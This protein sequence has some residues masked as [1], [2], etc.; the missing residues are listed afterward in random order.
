[1]NFFKSLEALI[2]A[3]IASI[4][5][6]YLANSGNVFGKFINKFL[7]CQQDPVTSFPC[8]AVYDLTIAAIVGLFVLVCVV[9]L[10]VNG[11]NK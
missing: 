10:I 11:F 2:I 8:Y 3:I 4:I 7:P 9:A 5:V 6:I 1:M